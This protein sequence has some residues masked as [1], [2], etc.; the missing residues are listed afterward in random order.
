M[1]NC[2]NCFYQGDMNSDENGNCHVFC[3]VKGTWMGDTA[4]CARFRE[5]ADLSR[6]I[7]AEFAS[8]MRQEEAEDRRLK[9]IVRSN[10]RVVI[11]TFIIS[12]ILFIAAVKFFDKFIF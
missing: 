6:E 12:F 4:T 8:E 9:A 10:W 11:G 5:L 1:G 7:R 3:M 2:V